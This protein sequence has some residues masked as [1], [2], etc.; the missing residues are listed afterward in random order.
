M[1]DTAQSARQQSLTLSWENVNAWLPA[2]TTRQCCGL[3]APAPERKA[4]KPILRNVNGIVYPGQLVAIVGASGSGKTTLLNFLNKFNQTK[5]KFAGDVRVNGELISAK[6]MPLISAFVQQQDLF[7]GT[8]T[9][10]EHLRFQAYLRM[11][12]QYSD[13]ERERRVEEVMAELGLNK[14]RSTI[15]G[16][17]GRVKG[18]S[19][20]EMK[21]LSFAS[22]VL[23]DPP[24]MFC[25]E[26]TSGL[27]SFMAQTVVQSLKFL[28]NEKRK[29]VI[30]VIHQPSSEVFELFDDVIILSEGRVAY[31]GKVAE[32]LAFFSRLGYPCPSLYNPADFFIFILAI[33]NGKEQEC[34]QRSKQICDAF[35]ASDTHARLLAD[36]D[37]LKKKSKGGRFKP[38]EAA[39]DDDQSDVSD[40]EIGKH[41]KMRKAARY[42]ASWFKQLYWVTKR[43][44]TTLL[45]DP[46]LL[47]IRLAQQVFLG[48]L[49]GVLYLRTSDRYHYG[50]SDVQNI[51]GVLLLLLMNQ[52]FGNMFGVV[53]SFTA[54]LPVFR[55]E[56]DNAV[57]R[58]D[59][60]YLSKTLV[61]LPIF[62]VL[63][64][65]MTNIV[66][67]MAG[68]NPGWDAYFA[69]C[70]VM[71]LVANCA[72]SF[73]YC[74][75]CLAGSIDLALAMSPPMLILLLLFAGF[76][77]NTESIPVYFYPLAYISW[78]K[79]GNE[80]LNVAQWSTVDSIGCASSNFSST[81]LANFT[82]SERHPFSNRPVCPYADGNA[83]LQQFHYKS[84]NFVWDLCALAALLI[85]YRLLGF[86]I[87]FARMWRRSSTK[88]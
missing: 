3:R 43:S 61:D 64:L 83:V 79:Y 82:S 24:I 51:N 68:F 23:T 13:A 75:S 30:C 17:P 63:P 38:M 71:I 76:F 66:Y 39:D 44:A 50:L 7:I 59:V 34:F 5:L 4:D 56:H 22:E 21:R 81:G 86:F 47:K 57:Y 32:A 19:G 46:A 62:V 48:L 16:V 33:Q 12:S 54:E 72:V 60:Y 53:N 15:I 8:L 45:R 36:A 69:I 26:P 11:G 78:F 2:D 87:L 9:V 29:T 70:G 85:I 37:E 55:R 73:G 77:L 28:A 49:F 65:I 35:D 25:D 80:A 14:C 52:S 6:N 88:K 31:Q 1:P 74:I 84:D 20:G 40:A 67:W 41:A 27:D 42:K 18:I 58:I 10:Y